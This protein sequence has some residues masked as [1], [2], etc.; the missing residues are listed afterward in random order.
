MPVV[1]DS[2]T[3]TMC[4]IITA[5]RHFII[6]NSPCR[7]RPIH[8]IKRHYWYCTIKERFRAQKGNVFSREQ[9]EESGANY[10]RMF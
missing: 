3:G 9:I 7:L 1:P 2:A 5:Q 8:S 4:E 6:R 10:I